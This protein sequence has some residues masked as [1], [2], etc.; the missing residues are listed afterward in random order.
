ME[1]HC[2]QLWTVGTMPGR[3]RVAG[4]Q[5]KGGR[6]AA[7]AVGDWERKD[8]IHKGCDGVMPTEGAEG[9]DGFDRR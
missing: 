4:V 3:V 8:S 1:A 5:G 6:G 7:W 9:D 2:Q